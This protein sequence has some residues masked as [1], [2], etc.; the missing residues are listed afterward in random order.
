MSDDQSQFANTQ[1]YKVDIETVYNSF[2]KQIDLVRSNVSVAKNSPI[3]AQFI[4]NL[5]ATSPSTTPLRSKLIIDTNNVQEPRCHAFYRMLGLPS[6]E[7]GG[8]F[9]SPGLIHAPVVNTNQNSINLDQTKITVAQNL[10]KQGIYDLLDNREIILQNFRQIFSVSDINSSILALSSSKLRNF[11]YINEADPPDLFDTQVANQTYSFLDTL[12]SSQTIDFLGSDGYGYQD[13]NG[14]TPSGTVIGYLKHRPHILKPFMVDPRVELTINPPYIGAPSNQDNNTICK[15]IGAPFP[16]DKSQHLYVENV[17]ASSPMI[18]TICRTRFSTAEPTSNLSAR[19]QAIV[20]Y[21]KNTDLEQDPILL[22]QVFVNPTQSQEDIIL[23]RYINIM[24]SMMD[25]LFDSIH[26]INDTEIK[27]HWIPIP[28]KRGPEY[29]SITQGLI[30]GDLSN[31]GI[32]QEIISKIV[33]NEVQQI[34][35]QLTQNNRPDLGNFID[36]EKNQARPD[37]QSTDGFGNTNQETLDTMTSNR[38][39][40][41]DQANEALRKIEIIMGEFSGL[42]LC[43]IIAIY[44]ALWIIDKQDLVNMLDN[45]AFNRLYQDSSLRC[46]EVEARQGN[47]GNPTNSILTTMANFEKQIIANY[48]LMQKLHDDRFTNNGIYN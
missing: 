8:S 39:A 21:V 11:N 3:I 9:Y 42:G 2:I 20:A 6:L 25:V 43:D 37:D 5:N 17:Y 12:N 41:T 18:E 23:L 22:Q 13:S 1:T 16:T 15:I 24:R 36:F 34:T 10:L 44:L 35:N 27:Y 45:A 33:N 28:D 4:K 19:L 30:I 40:Q 29:G 7:P 38:T 32:D 47:N 48:A 46:E 31:T 14:N 26:I